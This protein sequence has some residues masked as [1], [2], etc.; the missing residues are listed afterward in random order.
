MTLA[1]YTELL[2]EVRKYAKRSGLTDGD[3]YVM[4]AEERIKYGHGD[5]GD[6]YFTEPVRIS[7]MIE[8]GT[9]EVDQGDT[10]ATLPPGFLEFADTPYV[11]ASSDYE[12]QPV[13]M[14]NRAMRGASFP[15]CF[16]EY[17]IIGDRMKFTSAATEDY[18]VPISYYKLTALSDSNPTN[19]LLTARPSIYL[20]G[21]LLEV[22]IFLRSAEL[23]AEHFRQFRAAVHG[24]RRFEE[25]RRLTGPLIVRPDTWTP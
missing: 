9:L 23:A 24:S 4:L 20:Y 13:S 7:E 18:S 22:D 3:R 10:Y 5:M 2:A 12:M 25:N 16:Q 19:A 6:P 8:N 17:I 21:T 1:S 15:S 11:D 14:S